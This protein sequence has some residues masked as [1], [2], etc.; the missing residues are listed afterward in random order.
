MFSLIML[1][2]S[3]KSRPSRGS[4]I[5]TKQLGDIYIGKGRDPLWF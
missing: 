3:A 1:Y 2:M 5:Q 4:S